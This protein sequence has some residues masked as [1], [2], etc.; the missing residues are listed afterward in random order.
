MVVSLK[1]PTK[2]ILEALRARQ[3]YAG[4]VG[5]NATLHPGST[6]TWC[7]SPFLSHSMN[8]RQAG[9]TPAQAKRRSGRHCPANARGSE[10]SSPAQAP[11]QLSLPP[12]CVSGVWLVRGCTPG[13]RQQHC[14]GTGAPSHLGR[15]STGVP[16]QSL[17]ALKTRAT[18]AGGRAI[19]Q[20]AREHSSHRRGASP[21][22]E[23]A[24]RASAEKGPS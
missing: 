12:C 15:G 1:K 22:A 16:L 9:S 20:E 3:A 7:C 4:G 10:R 6:Q 2:P 23:T 21:G 13:L 18:S 11:P 8:P 19:W 24:P 5:G 14:D 17:V